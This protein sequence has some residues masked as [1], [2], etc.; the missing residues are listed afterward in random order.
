MTAPAPPPS[1]APF[2]VGWLPVPREYLRFLRPL[3]AGLLFAAGALAL[4]LALSQPNPGAGRWDTESVQTFDGIV[5]ARPYAT[6]R[7]AGTQP[8]DPPRTL[9]LVEEGKFGAR[10]RVKALM[11]GETGPVAVRVSG[12]V[13]QRNGRWMLELAAGDPGLR[14]LSA[15][16]ARGLPS[17]D[18]P[19][20]EVLAEHITLSG[21]VIDPKCYLGA[22]K[23]GGG[24]THKACA[25]L[26]ISGGIPPMLVTRD[27]AQSETFYL[28]TMAGGAVANEHVLPFVGDLVEVTGRVERH[29]DLLVLRIAP[30]GVRRR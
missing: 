12:T 15:D 19:A 6:L 24:K 8:G 2:F 20:P 29:G 28:L 9:L 30:N 22:M 21:E 17:L 11:Q 18:W 7:T 3:A 4:A 25:M 23:P 27:G 10:P 14:R 13:L 5:A 26:C 16:E 1:D